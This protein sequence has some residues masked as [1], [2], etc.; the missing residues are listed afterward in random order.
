M[1]KPRQIKTLDRIVEDVRGAIKDMVVQHGRAAEGKMAEKPE[2]LARVANMTGL[3]TDLYQFYGYKFDFKDGEDQ[4]PVAVYERALK[5]VSQSLTEQRERML[6]LLDSI[7]GAIIEEHCP[8]N[9]PPED[10]D[11]K[12]IKT[13][14]VEHFGVKPVNYDNVHDAGDLAHILFTQAEAALETKEKDMGTELMLRVFRHFYLEEIDRAWVEHLTNMEHLRDGIG[15]RGYGQRDPKQ[16]YKKEGYDIFVTMMA[17]V[18]SNTCTKLFEVKVQRE[19][20]IERIE[21]E[22]AAKHHA[23]QRSMQARHGSELAGGEEEAAVSRR[24]LPPPPR[25][26][27]APERRTAPQIERND[28]CPC[29]SGLKFKKCHGAAL[30]EEGG[31]ESEATP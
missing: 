17:A 23:Q 1:G 7:V 16:E 27:Q 30:E 13:G 25:I 29:G 22:D 9:V 19:T 14:F 21:R 26:S 28:L 12:G 10:W 2:D 24:S 3:Q 6:D 5:E 20:E 18:S 31:D 15:L 8:Q 4:K 11:V